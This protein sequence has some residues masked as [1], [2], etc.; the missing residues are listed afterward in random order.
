MV[1]VALTERDEKFEEFLIAEHQ[2]LSE[3][4]L[5]NEEDGE[6]RITF[7]IT[8]AG[9]LGA[10][11]AFLGGEG[12]TVGDPLIALALAALLLLGHMSYLRVV[13][14][15]VVTDSYLDGLNRVRRYFLDHTN[16]PQAA[17]YLPFLPPATPKMRRWEPGEMGKGGRLETVALVNSLLAGTFVAVLPIALAVTNEWLFTGTAGLIVGIVTWRKLIL[18]ANRRYMRGREENARNRAGTKSA[19]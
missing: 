13:S 7:L 16:T 12:A 4:F 1:E 8:L 11:I 15:N 6:K 9:G 10:V 5:R 18:S 3:A 19:R 14:R 17:E 2:Q